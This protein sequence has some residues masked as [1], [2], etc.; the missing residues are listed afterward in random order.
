MMVSLTRLVAATAPSFKLTLLPASVPQHAVFVLY[1]DIPYIEDRPSPSQAPDESSNVSPRPP[2][3]RRSRARPPQSRSTDARS[4]A[5]TDLQSES[6]ADGHERSWESSDGAEEAG[7]EGRP[8]G[9]ESHRSR[10]RR[11]SNFERF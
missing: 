9:R 1:A 5:P 3:P 6:S 8:K 2:A 11:K 10:G 4:P 7:S